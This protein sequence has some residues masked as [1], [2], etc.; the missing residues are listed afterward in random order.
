MKKKGKINWGHPLT[1]FIL[2]TVAG[3]AAWGFTR[4]WE[5]IDRSDL[6]VQIEHPKQAIRLVS[7]V[8]PSIDGQTVFCD[9]VRFALVIAHNQGGKSPVAINDI[10]VNTTP[11][12][13]DPSRQLGDECSIDVL[14]SRPYGIAERKAIILTVADSGVTGRYIESAKEGDAWPIDPHNILDGAKKKLS[15]TLKPGEEPVSFDIALES[16]T[17][18]LHKVWFTVNYDAA[19]P[20]SLNTEPILIGRT[21][22]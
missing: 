21:N 20:K 13:L 15:I 10:S 9:T 18:Q 1:L 6:R 19:G 17:S 7:N 4:I 14:A 16:K 5:A 11:V 22:P 8:Q 3:A 12:N 2:S